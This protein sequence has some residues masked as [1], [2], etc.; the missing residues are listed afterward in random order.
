MLFE[1]RGS[2]PRSVCTIGN[3]LLIWNGEDLH[4]RRSASHPQRVVR[5]PDT[6]R[7]TF[8]MIGKGEVLPKHGPMEAVP[9]TQGCF[10]W[11]KQEFFLREDRRWWPGLVFGQQ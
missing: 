2:L 10:S 7:S 1:T 8:W 5:H 9:A 6:R 11:N 4:L 3:D